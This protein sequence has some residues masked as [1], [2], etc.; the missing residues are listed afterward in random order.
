M[1][2]GT[3]VR[4]ATHQFQSWMSLAQLAKGLV[5]IEQQL[6]VVYEQAATLD[7]RVDMLLAPPAVV[8]A[9]DITDVQVKPVKKA[10]GGKPGRRSKA[11]V[12][13]EAAAAALEPAAKNTRKTKA[14]AKK[15]RAAKADAA[16]PAGEA[17]APAKRARGSKHSNLDK[18]FAYLEGQLNRDEFKP[19]TQTHVADQA[20]IPKGSINLALRQLVA[21]GRIIEG[22][23]GSYKLP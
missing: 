4:E 22:E 10:K 3:A 8:L 20:G 13:A 21:Q 16:A 11:I 14:V 18:V 7:A 9:S 23:R 17:A 12:A 15:A 19:Q 2:G 6:R 5:D 1:A